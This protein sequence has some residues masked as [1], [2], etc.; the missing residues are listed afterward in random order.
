MLSYSPF[1]VFFTIF[2]NLIMGEA[3]FMAAKVE[4]T[5]KKTVDDTIMAIKI[6]AKIFVKR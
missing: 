5:T 1:F 3:M 4:N 2:D 6:S